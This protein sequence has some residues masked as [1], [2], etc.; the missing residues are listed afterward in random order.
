[1]SAQITKARRTRRSAP[2]SNLTTTKEQAPRMWGQTPAQGQITTN[3]EFSSNINFGP[4][5]TM[6]ATI[7][8]THAKPGSLPRLIRSSLH[9]L[10]IIGL[11]CGLKG[12]PW[13]KELCRGNL[14]VRDWHPRGVRGQFR[15]EIQCEK[16]RA[17]DPNGWARQ[18]EILPAARE[19][20]HALLDIGNK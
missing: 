6:N 11:C 15:Y 18:D 10:K 20:F 4:P 2:G 3:L 14:F 17:C 19:H 9:H 12:R 7:K 1:M 13:E 8:T 5:S 16:C